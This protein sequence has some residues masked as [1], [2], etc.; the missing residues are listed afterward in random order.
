M[1]RRSTRWRF[2][3]WR[4][5]AASFLLL[6]SQLAALKALPY[7]SSLIEEA[8]PSRDD[9]RPTPD[10]TLGSLRWD[11]SAYKTDPKLEPFR[12]YFRAKCPD[13]TGLSAAR[14]IAQQFVDQ[15]HWGQPTHEFLASRYDPAEDFREHLK[16][17]SGH[18]VSRA[19]FLA[20]ILLSV[21]IPA[22]V[23]QLV[24]R[25]GSAGGHNLVEVWDAAEGWV[26]VDPSYGDLVYNGG[27]YCSALD[28]LNRPTTIR[29]RGT[30]TANLASDPVAYYESQDFPLR[31]G[32]LMYP[33]PWLYL[34]TGPRAAPWP[35][36]GKFA[37]VGKQTWRFGPAQTL[38]YC[39]T[40]LSAALG[41]CLLLAHVWSYFRR[42]SLRSNTLCPHGNG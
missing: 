39:G 7:A 41:L 3:L 13:K 18:C 17:A 36:R 19:G 37:L 4:G 2:T 20:A 27:G 25:Q 30:R 15:L 6:A 14:C 1:N 8:E 9:P 22:R 26:L 11:V 42:G 34:R 12:E 28:A 16:G 24:P 32:V 5:A 21:G 31:D 33:E 40:L 23:V 38:L 29:W 35:F 10:F